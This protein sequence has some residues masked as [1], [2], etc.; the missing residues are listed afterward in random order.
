MVVGVPRQ[1]HE[2]A[3]PHPLVSGPQCRQGCH[4]PLRN[5]AV[6]AAVLAVVQ[7]AAVA[8]AGIFQSPPASGRLVCDCHNDKEI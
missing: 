6:T 2:S 4:E 8:R 5:L 7:R 1:T 3:Q